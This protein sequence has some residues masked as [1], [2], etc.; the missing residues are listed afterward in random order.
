MYYHVFIK[1]VNEEGK[2]ERLASYHY[3]EQHL[4]RT[5]ADPFNEGKF[6]WILG[7]K[8]HPSQ[9]REIHIFASKI[10]HL[11]KA[12]LP[13]GETLIDE[14]D[15]DYA[16]E[17]LVTGRVSECIGITTP[18]F[19]N[20]MEAKPIATQFKS[21]TEKS[22]IFI[23]HGRDK[24]S[25][26]TLQKHLTKD[27]KLDAEMFE[28]YRKKNTSSTII[29]VLEYIIKK[30]SYVFIVVTPDD[31]G[32]LR[33]TIEKCKNS[34][35][36]KTSVRVSTLCNDIFAKLVTRPRQNVTFEHGL[37]VGVLG[38]DRVCCLLHKEVR[39]RPSDIHGI[40]YVPFEESV[41]DK[42]AEIRDKLKEAKI[43]KE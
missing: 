14:N 1:F 2:E 42:F 39:E 40:L 20:P 4:R 16:T 29:E 7:K 31:V 17:N 19:I 22:K 26:L 23:V 30:V 6:F 32:C 27:L 34:L 33:K 41:E 13:N 8:V 11:E 15:F 37:F 12:I 38:R 3:T 28:D 43:I 35:I 25:A 9:V 5:V 21:K 24:A 36:G 18:S 10:K